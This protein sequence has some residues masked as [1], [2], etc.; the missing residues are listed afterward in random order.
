MSC[1]AGAGGGLGSAEGAAGAAVATVWEARDLAGLAIRSETV[2]P[3][4]ARTTTEL[5][6][7]RLDPD[8]S[9]FEPPAGAERVDRL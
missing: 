5:V 7:V 8:P 9:L 6:D 2:D 4:G 3:D 1:R